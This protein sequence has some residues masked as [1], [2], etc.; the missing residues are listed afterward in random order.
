[1]EKRNLSLNCCGCET[2]S[3]CCPSKAIKILEDDKGFQSPVIDYEKCSDCGIC[4]RVCTYKK[5][6]EQGM[7]KGKIQNA[8][9]F[10]KHK[11]RLLSQSGGA[12]SAIAEIILDAG[13]IVYGVTQSES[14]VFYCRIDNTKELKKLKGS[15]YVQADVSGIYQ[16]CFNDLIN[17]KIVLVS[18]TPCHIAGLYSFLEYKKCNI[19]NLLTVDLICHGVPSPLFFRK[20]YNGM[21]EK[22]GKIKK[23]NFRYKEKGNWGAHF[24]K[25]YLKNKS[26]I[27]ENWTRIFYSNLVLR[28]SCYTCPYSTNSRIGDITIGDCWGIE[29]V[30][31]EVDYG[32]GVSLV[33]TNTEKGDYWR[34][35]IEKK[36]DMYQVKLQ[37]L[38][39]QNLRQPTERP[40]Q[41]EIFWDDFYRIGYDGCI[42]KYCGFDEEKVE[43]RNLQYD[44]VKRIGK[45]M[46]SIK[47][48][49]KNM[50]R[51]STK[52]EKAEQRLK[53]EFLSYYRNTDNQEIK[54][55]VE[56]IKKTNKFGMM[57]CELSKNY[58]D[59]NVKVN[60]SAEKKLPYVI[61]DGK[62]LFFPQNR[63]EERVKDNYIALL[64]EQ[65]E[66]S[67]HR[68]LVTEDIDM[69]KKMHE[70]GDY[71]RLF[72]FGAAE[73]M[74]SLKLVEYVDELYLFE[75]NEEWMEALNETFKP[76][77]DKVVIVNKYVGN[78]NDE[79]HITLDSFM[80]E[81]EI[82]ENCYNI[83]KMDIEGAEIAALEGMK[84]FMSREQA[85]NLYV[86][87]Y[88]RQDDENKVKKICKEYD[89]STN[90]GYFCFFADPE[91]SAPF[92]RRCLVKVKKNWK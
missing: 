14:Q 35:K 28:D 27:S 73:A 83:V 92:V 51:K 42:K 69:V 49:I 3:L 7:P 62:K 58:S 17:N 45:E 65:D 67:P 15:K 59:L 9:T 78:Y 13:G 40:L 64:K 90:K 32:D 11:G 50:L 31:P 25:I 20:Y 72:E 2:C 76:W 10:I 47:I 38:M 44:K 43:I 22:F 52:E 75:C 6:L 61:D 60:F 36:G 71:I 86:C 37:N 26:I 82:K 57:N 29:K 19:D 56:Y 91:Y 46:G 34:K 84:K 21:Q 54:S 8:Y 23:F 53:K 41:Y 63:S 74:F 16:E 85:F 80:N 88:H 12:F 77:K 89:I 4:E 30:L 55:M 70:R 18:G 66:K 87:T 79:S 81:I 68:Y 1:M 24:E 5:Y 39:Q 48:K 33:I